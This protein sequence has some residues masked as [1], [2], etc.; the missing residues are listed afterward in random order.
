MISMNL[1][2]LRAFAL[3]ALAVAGFSP[4]AGAEDRP[5]EAAARPP[6]FLPFD[7]YARHRDELGLTADQ[8]R[9]MQRLADGMRDSAREL[10]DNRRECTKAL[11]VVTGRNPVNSDKAMERFRALLKAEDEMKALQFR[12]EIAMRNTLSPEQF[13]KLESLAAKEAAS[14]G[15]SALAKLQERLQQLKAELHKQTGGEPP[16]E[17]VERIEQ[18]ELAAK[19]GRLG[20]AKDQLEQVLRRLHGEAPAATTADIPRPSESK[21]TPAHAAEPERSLKEKIAPQIDA[22]TEAAKSTDDPGL[23]EQLQGALRGLR[24]AAASGNQEAA[25]KILRSIEPALQK[26]SRGKKE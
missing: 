9:A 23:R 1:R 24:D 18:I 5:R 20:E 7:F 2:S 4:A 8:I 12:N 15:D 6:A 11:Q 3:F 26:M 21:P 13:G 17:I 22:I 16:R 14:R 10:E 25:D 19:N